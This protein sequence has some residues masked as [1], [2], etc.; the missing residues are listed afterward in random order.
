MNHLYQKTSRN[1][2]GTRYSLATIGNLHDDSTLVKP[3]RKP[4]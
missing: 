4:H 2:S 1:L 3:R